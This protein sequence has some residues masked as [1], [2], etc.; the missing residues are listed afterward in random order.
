MPV[1]IAQNFDADQLIV[2]I[3]KH[4]KMYYFNSFMLICLG[5]LGLCAPMITATLVDELIGALLLITGLSQS[6]F[7]FS[8]NR[9]WVNYFLAIIA[10]IAGVLM[11]LQPQEGVGALS[12]ILLVYLFLQG[13]LQI[14]FAVLCRECS[15]AGWL[16]TS[17]IVSVLLS[18]LIGV[19]LPVVATWILGWIVGANFIILGLSMIM[20]I[21]YVNR[22]L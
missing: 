5:V 10:I 6:G 4:F 19:S 2:D 21:K 8:T 22:G 13:V 9:H 14:L 17:G 12:L 1:L 7:S 16:F 3:R 20:L 15:G 11:L 18:L